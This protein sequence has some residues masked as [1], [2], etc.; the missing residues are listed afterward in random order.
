[1]NIR[2]AILVAI[3]AATTTSYGDQKHPLKLCGRWKS[4]EAPTGYWII[5]RYPNGRYAQKRYLRNDYALPGEI[6]LEWGKWSVSHKRYQEQTLGTTTV[7]FSKMF[8]PKIGASKILT[9]TPQL[10]EYEVAD[11]TWTETRLNNQT[12]LSTLTMPPPQLPDPPKSWHDTTQK[13]GVPDWVR[14]S[15]GIPVTKPAVE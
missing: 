8:K 10:F 2:L 9:E 6:T 5:D 4:S 7:L 15:T 12:P 13:P 14:A 1:M 3:L 11:G